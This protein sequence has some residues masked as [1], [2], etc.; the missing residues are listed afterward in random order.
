MNESVK[1]KKITVLGA[2][3]SG[4]AAA[5]MLKN[6]GA[7]VYVSDSAPLCSKQEQAAELGRAGIAFEFGQHTDRAYQADFAVLSPGIPVRSET[8]QKFVRAGIPVYSEIETASWFC[9]SP[10]IAVT[11]SNGKTTTTT[12]IGEMLKAHFPHPIVAGNIGSPFSAF[13]ANSDPQS[14]AVVEVSSFQLE[15]IDRFH[16]RVAVVLNFAPNH[17]DRYDSYEDYLQAKW[18][19]TKNLQRDDLLVYNGSDEKLSEWSSKVNSRRQGFFIQQ[20]PQAAAWF[21][22][23][24]LY[25][26]GTKLLD[27]KEMALRG[28]HNYMNALAAALAAREVGIPVEA[29]VRVLRAFRGIEHRLEAVAEI[30]GVQYINDSKAT[31][32][33][34][35]TVALQSFDTPVVLIAGGKD[36]G[37]DFS[38]LNELIRSRVKECVLIGTAADKM[39]AAWQGLA[40]LYRAS[41]LQDAVN[42][43][44]QTARPGE[45]VLLSPACASFDMFA[46]FEDRGRQFKSLVKKLQES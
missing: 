19:I 15:T 22:G 7:D 6:L 16:P 45:V 38:K 17:L 39:A 18:R 28:P 14:P 4:V 26:K 23:A 24:A 37:S 44:R 21:D 20:N 40:P 32:I 5:K 27:V 31:T 10:L 30:D 8:V 3:R 36:K 42:R 29:I 43:A 2:A 9:R 35:L 46:D 1:N 33:E 12:L 25:V 13:A 41:S 34:S 11:G